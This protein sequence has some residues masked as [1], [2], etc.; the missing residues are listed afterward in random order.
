M[1]IIN[2]R[3]LSGIL[4]YV[5]LFFA[6]TAFAQTNIAIKKGYHGMVEIGTST[7]NGQ[8]QEGFIKGPNDKY[9][10]DQ[11]LPGEMVRLSTVHGYAWGNGL[12]LGAGV[13]WDFELVN[14]AQ[15]ASIF[16][17]AKYNIKDAAASPFIEGRTGYR[18]CTNAYRYDTSGT[19]VSFATGVDF[20]NAAIRLGY[21]YSPIRQNYR[22]DIGGL[23]RYYYTMNQFFFSAAFHF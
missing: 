1:I 16:A 11:M 2:S 6:T 7:V 19:F 3:A 12:F 22:A 18:I 23:H 8:V 20:G 21:E 4:C 10:K 15:Y 5:A 9:E 13:G 14:S 17:A